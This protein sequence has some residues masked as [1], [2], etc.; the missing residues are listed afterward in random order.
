[1]KP[2]GNSSAAIRILAWV[3]IALTAPGCSTWQTVPMNAQVPAS[4]TIM[5]AELKLRT[6]DGRKITLYNWTLEGDTLRGS[7]E[8]WEKGARVMKPEAIA[9]SMVDY[10]EGRTDG[11]V[12][13]EYLA[14]KQNEL[15]AAREQAAAPPPPKEFPGVTRFRLADGSAIELENAAVDGDSLRG[16]V[17]V[18]TSDPSHRLIILARKDV[19]YV[20]TEKADTGKTVGLAV[21]IV[22]V[23]LGALLVWAIATVDGD[24]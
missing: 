3:L 11:E 13:P 20:E 2:A 7:R 16:R 18:T 21:G 4:R 15:V 9:L 1:V 8:A 5:P 19:L 24:W 14:A 6:S 10:R 12:L 22:V 17:P 23:V